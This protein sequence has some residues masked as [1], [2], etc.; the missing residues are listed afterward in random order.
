MVLIKF[1]PNPNNMGVYQF[2]IVPLSLTNY[3][4]IN[5]S[6]KILQIKHNIYPLYCLFFIHNLLSCSCSCTSRSTVC[7]DNATLRTEFFVFGS[8][9]YSSPSMWACLFIF[10]MR[11]LHLSPPT[12]APAVCPSADCWTVPDRT[13]AGRRTFPLPEG[14]C[15]S[16]PAEG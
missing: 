12:G 6:V 10:R 16:S 11:F 2:I 8:V 13:Y 4:A 9:T 14:I 1:K 7:C 15:R 3:K 5:S